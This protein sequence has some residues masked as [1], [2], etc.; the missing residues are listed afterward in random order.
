M[1]RILLA[2][3]WCVAVGASVALGQQPAADAAVLRDYF[4]GNGLLN[5]GMYDL[6]AAE[7]R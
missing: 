2:A 5:R 1:L 3:A 4:A 7:Y 6:A